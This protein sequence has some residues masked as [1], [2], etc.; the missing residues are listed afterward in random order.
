MIQMKS[1]LTFLILLSVM[2]GV[3]ADYMEQKC[4]YNRVGSYIT[5]V[6]SGD[7]DGD[8]LNE[9]FAGTSDGVVMNFPYGNCKIR[10]GPEWQYIQ[11]G[12]GRGEILQMRV[13]DLENDGKNELIVA[14]NSREDYLFVLDNEGVFK[15]RDDSAGGFVLSMDVAD[16]DDDNKKEIIL[17]NRGKGV[18]ALDGHNDI[19]W[20]V[21][22][23]NPVY[24][25]KAID[26]DND[27]NLDIVALTNKDLISATIYVLDNEGEII[28]SYSID[29]G[30]YQASKNSIFIADLNNDNK[31]E[32]LVAT[33]K[34]GIM[35]L[36]HDGNLIWGYPTNN[37][38]N[39]VCV[40][41]LNQDN[42]PEIIFGSN[43][44]IYLLDR[45]GN[46]KLKI[47]INGSARTMFSSDLE[48]DGVREI[49]IGTDNLIQVI[50]GEGKKKGEWRIGKNVNKISIC[51][52]D[53]NRDNRGEIIAGFG[54]EESRLEQ[55]HYS[56]E[57]HVFE[58]T[59]IVEVTTTAPTTTTT[60]TTLETTSTTITVTTT[61]TTIPEKE[62]SRSIPLILLIIVMIVAMIIAVLL[63][64]EL[65]KRG[66]EE[67]KNE[68]EVKKED[69]Q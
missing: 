29:E 8:G 13:T 52:A 1:I 35:V 51:V 57:L 22:L 34:K 45:E 53:L 58:V 39:S 48:N 65:L 41:D 67:G 64:K 23:D 12:S 47:N 24:F 21:D 4:V 56:G 19:K 69:G 14:A 15:W 9:I 44:Y 18:I 30:I 26:I 49:T 2:G 40:S 60:T 55:E 3:G 16:I 43:P 50:D 31:L 36:G 61:T 11:T 62:G 6:Y 20:R 38:V 17:G 10:W 28:W 27:G 42:E 59:K 46:L 32:I 5:S 37:V 33:H 66:D 7:L 68:R 54:W 25:V 63:L